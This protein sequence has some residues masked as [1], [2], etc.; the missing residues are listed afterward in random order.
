MDDYEYMPFLSPQQNANLKSLFEYYSDHETRRRIMRL[1]SLSSEDVVQ[2]FQ[3]ALVD[4]IDIKTMESIISDET[5]R[6]QLVELLD[7]ILTDLEKLTSNSLHLLV[8]K[9]EEKYEYPKFRQYVSDNPSISPEVITM[10][11]NSIVRDAREGFHNE[12][13]SRSLAYNKNT[14]SKVL[15]KLF[16]IDDLT[17][18]TL[19]AKHGNT[20]SRTLELFANHKSKQIRRLISEAPNSTPAMQ[21]NVL[22]ENDLKAVEKLARNPVIC[23]EAVAALLI[24]GEILPTKKRLKQFLDDNPEYYNL[25]IVKQTS[26]LKPKRGIAVPETTEAELKEN[27]LKKIE[28]LMGSL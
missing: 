11:A 26:G 19:I 6:G 1:C 5:K 8:V 22:K 23:D 14:D 20:E 16:I 7:C 24:A 13:E 15:H 25:Q 21:L 18:R 17:T 2:L 9:L 10:I 12:I 3:N 27:H 4:K 28:A